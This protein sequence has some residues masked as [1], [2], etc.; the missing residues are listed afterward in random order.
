[1]YLFILYKIVCLHSLFKLC[2]PGESF[3]GRSAY[4]SP[5]PLLL[6]LPWSLH[7][8][9]LG[10]HGALRR[11][12]CCLGFSFQVTFLLCRWDD[13]FKGQR[14]PDTPFTS[15]RWWPWRQSSS[16]MESSGWRVPSVVVSS[17]SSRPLVWS[18]PFF[19]KEETSGW[20]TDFS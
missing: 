17:A 7:R 4:N 11:S 1:M 12:L 18:S 10:R 15:W 5:R 13:N 16:G 2:L 14:R 6:I 3:T 20:P 19:L 8:R 9:H